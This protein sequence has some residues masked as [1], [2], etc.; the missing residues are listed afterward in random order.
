AHGG[1]LAIIEP[2][3]GE[4][5]G[6]VG[7]ADAHDVERASTLAAQAQREWA[8]APFMERAAVL[9]RAGA[10]IEEHAE[11]LQRWMIRETGSVAGMA[12]FA[13]HVASQECYE[14]AALASRP[15]GEILPTEQPRLSLLRRVPVG[16]VGVISPLDRKSTRL[17]SSH[18]K[19][20]YAV[21]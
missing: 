12:Q 1:E 11:E 5:M 14:A 16:V 10:L 6:R 2:A 21:F 18:V 19:I 9:R 7:L 13:T 3:T 20:S 17:N 15:L 8:A 4:E